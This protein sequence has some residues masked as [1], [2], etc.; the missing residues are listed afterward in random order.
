MLDVENLRKDFP[1]IRSNP[2]LVYFDNAATTFKPQTVIDAVTEF[3]TMNTSNVERGDYPLAARTDSLFNGARTSIARLINCDPKEI[4]FT[5]NDTA[6]MNQIAYGMQHNFLKEGEVIL[7][8][9]AE[10]ASNLLPWFRMEKES[11]IKV[12]F[13]ETDLQGRVSPE[14][15][16]NA[17]HTGVKAIALA[18]VT[19]VLGS[20]QPIKEAAAIAHENG[21][22]MIVDGAQS[23]PHRR[24]DVKDTDIDFLAFSGH[25]MCGP[26]GI[27]VLYGKYELLQKMD[28]IMLGGG[29][30]ARFQSCGDITLKD[31]PY[32]FEAGT[33]NIEGAIGMG[34]AAEYLLSIGM[35]E[36]SAYE[37]DLRKYFC[38]KISV[39]DNLEFYN[40]DNEYGPIAFNAKGVFAQDAAGYLASRGIAV[41]SG[42]HCA[43]L[44]HEIIGTDQTIR[45]SI[46]FYNTRKDVDAFVEAAKDISLKNAVGIFF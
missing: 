41:R 8:T 34:R 14:N 36:I 31:A 24:T 4:C 13:I 12:E 9:E 30:N 10:H 1:M 38:E 43:K 44:L 18:E 21:A 32:R 33:P 17:M 26:S 3:Y 46:Y 2:D 37:K 39:L 11:G 20:L 7:T 23:V 35:D 42:N 40:P 6:A 19:N 28:P 22:L 29:M 25:K 15:I 27:G 16:R 5:A 45:A